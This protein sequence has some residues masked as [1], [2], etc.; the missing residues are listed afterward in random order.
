[1]SIRTRRRLKW[2]FILMAVIMIIVIVFLVFALKKQDEE[3]KEKNKKTELESTLDRI[4]EMEELSTFKVI[5][6]GVAEV[7]DAEDP[8]KIDYH[9]SYE[10]TVKL[11]IDVGKIRYDID[12][13]QKEIQIT[14]PPVRVTDST[15]K[16]ESMDYIFVNKKA[17][18]ETVSEQA[19]RECIRDLKE[20][21]HGQKRIYKLARQNAENIVRAFVEPFIGQMD[22]EF[23]VCLKWEGDL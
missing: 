6:N 8:E 4:T 22:R 10:G 16:A 9:V 2:L 23:T 14:L 18:T 3:R 1:M 13:E 7:Y 5:Y 20:E 19:Y 17:D 11:G 21:T 15:V 12:W